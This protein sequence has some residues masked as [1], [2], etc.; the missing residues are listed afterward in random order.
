MKKRI[1]TSIALLVVFSAI[2]ISSFAQQGRFKGTVK[3]ELEWEGDYPPGVP[4]EMEIKVY[5]NKSSFTNILSMGEPVI[6]NSDANLIYSMYDF[7]T[8]PVDG[9]TGKWYYRNKVENE[10]L[11]KN[12]YTFLDETKE[13]AGMT[14]KKVEVKYEDK[15]GKEVEEIIWASDEIG[16]KID[17]LFYTGLKAMPFQF[18]LDAGDFKITFTVKEITK[19]KVK[20]AEM[21]IPTGYDEVSVEELQDIFETLME[22][23]GGGGGDDDF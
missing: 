10:E 4:T 6:T 22:A 20:S 19:G 23:L 18:D 13:I 21:L 12:T 8:I 9:V 7:S 16:P 2:S 3:Y 5:D 17:L 11:E 14:A 15:D 1:L